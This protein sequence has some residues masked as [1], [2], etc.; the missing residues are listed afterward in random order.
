MCM[1]VQ[2]V[3]VCPICQVPMEVWGGWQIALQ[4]ELQMG[5]SWP[6][7]AGN[8]VLL[9]RWAVSPVPADLGISNTYILKHTSNWSWCMRFFFSILLGLIFT[10]SCVQVHKQACVSF[11]FFFPNDLCLLLLL[12]WHCLHKMNSEI[13]FPLQFYEIVSVELGIKFTEF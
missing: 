3:C 2:H 4:L 8:L 11:D 6:V 1:F 7:G 13:F 9:N 10:E 12:G 5:M